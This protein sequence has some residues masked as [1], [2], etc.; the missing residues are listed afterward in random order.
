MLPRAL[1]T[2]YFSTLK[3]RGLPRSRWSIGPPARQQ[4]AARY[5]AMTMWSRA[6]R[7]DRRLMRRSFRTRSPALD[8]SLVQITRAANYS[9][10]WLFIA[11]V[12]ALLGGSRGRASAL[13]GVVAIAMAALVANGPAKLLVRRR[14]P[15]WRRQ[16]SLIP[17]PRSTS[18]P[19]GHGAAAFAFATGASAELPELAPLLFPLAGAVAY[20]RVHTGVHYPSDVVAGIAIGIGAGVL[21]ARLAR[22]ARLRAQAPRLRGRTRPGRR[23]PRRPDAAITI[24]ARSRAPARRSPPRARP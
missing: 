4:H 10:L 20:S 14:R 21:T 23:R 6:R 2:P 17:V 15:S 16:P 3:P 9:R 18:F 19:S 1:R 7:W 11:G 13:R 24:S 22:G 8:R 5:R 12:L